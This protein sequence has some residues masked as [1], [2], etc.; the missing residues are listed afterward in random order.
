MGKKNKEER[1]VKIRIHRRKKMV[2]IKKTELKEGIM[3]VRGFLK[4][5]ERWTT[6]AYEIPLENFGVFEGNLK[7]KLLELFRY[8]NM[9]T[10]GETSRLI[11]KLTDE[12]GEILPHKPKKLLFKT[13]SHKRKF[14]I[15][16]RRV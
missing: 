14:K 3:R 9:I 13:S 10:N 11:K 4:K 6:Q 1:Y 8:P 16:Q 7:K 15:K 5:D 12:Y 2:T